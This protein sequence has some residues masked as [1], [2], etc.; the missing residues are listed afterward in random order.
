MSVYF[1]VSLLVIILVCIGIVGTTR[2]EVR[3]AWDTVTK[4]SPQPVFLIPEAVRDSIDEIRSDF[5]RII[6]HAIDGAGKGTAWQRA[7]DICDQFGHRHVG[8]QGLEDAIDEMASILT[9]DSLENVRFE[10]LQVPKWTRGEESLHLVEPL[11]GG[12]ERRLSMLGMGMSTGTAPEGIEAEVLVVKDVG[13]LGQ[14]A[15]LAKGRI[16]IFHFDFTAYGSDRPYRTHGP[17][18]AA[19]LGAVA[20]GI[21]SLASFSLVSPH[22]GSL[23]YRSNTLTRENAASWGG[24]S[25]RQ[26][27]TAD[28]P[29]SEWC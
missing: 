2:G 29:M 17:S 15:D 22:T 19:K 11:A 25:P 8:E 21:S 1:L 10:P 20:A 4:G 23:S 13:E 3:K 7:A 28:M 24:S 5:D 26:P 12:K 14:K 6:D 18:F 27:L 9:E 16:V